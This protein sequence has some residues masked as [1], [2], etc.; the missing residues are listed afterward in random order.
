MAEGAVDEVAVDEWA[1]A[2]G[3]V[4]EVAVDEWAAAEGAVAEWA[5][6]GEVVGDVICWWLL[7]TGSQVELL[8]GRDCCGR[9]MGCQCRLDEKEAISGKRG[10]VGVETMVKKKRREWKT[11]NQKL[12]RWRVIGGGGS[13]NRWSYGGA[14]W[15]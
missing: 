5:A 8:V 14:V 10:R 13:S 1:A 2:E 11:H 6:A 15:V 12:K 9:L 3:A 7:R 4:A